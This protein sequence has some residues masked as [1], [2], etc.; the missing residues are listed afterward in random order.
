M[1]QRARLYVANFVLDER[2]T[3]LLYNVGYARTVTCKRAIDLMQRV[4]SCAVDHVS[5]ELE[6]G[7]LGGV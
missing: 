3:L 4:V 7:G 5:E 1:Q 2:Y 6:L